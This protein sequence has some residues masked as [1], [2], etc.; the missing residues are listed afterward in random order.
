MPFCKRGLRGVTGG[1]P[2]VE[3]EGTEIDET[4]DQIQT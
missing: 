2:I 1:S 4:S 3:E